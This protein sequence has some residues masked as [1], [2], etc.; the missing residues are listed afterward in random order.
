VAWGI[1][2][3]NKKDATFSIK[4]R[5]TISV[6]SLSSALILISLLFSFS[7]S[8]HEI[9]EVYDARLGQSA[10]MLLLSMPISEQSLHSDQT[11][12]LFDAWMQRIAA[13]SKRD[14]DPTPF[15]HPY[16]QNILVQFYFGENLIWGSIPGIGNI[17]HDPKYAGFGYMTLENESWRYFQLPL[18]SAPNHK[19]ESI[20]VAEK[21]S[22]R[23]EVI[24]E[25]ALSS[26]L[27]QLILIPCLALVMVLLID[28]HFEPLSELKL[29]IAQRSAN[30]LD[31]IYVPSATQE[32][33]P[34]VAALNDLLTELDQ[35]W[36]R[37]KRFTR[38]AAHELKTPLTILRLNAE[39]ALMSQNEQQLKSDLNNILQGIDRTDRLI[40]QLLTLAKVDSIHEMKFS[41]LN[42]SKLSKSV[43][44]ERVPLALTNKQDF[45][46]EGEDDVEIPGDEALLR[47]LLTNL[48]D[49]AIRYSG[50][51]S[52]I[53]V[54]V[55]KS[56]D[57][58]KVYVSDTGVDMSAETRQKLFDNFY[59]ANT[60]KGDGAGLG[61]SITRDIAKLH[62][63]SVELLP[64]ENDR[65]T[66][67][68][69]LPV[70]LLC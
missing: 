53:S 42:I 37:E 9:E 48:V 70:C 38:M 57:Q 19:P 68:V 13:Q 8:R 21:Q 67:L 33:S 15:G 24:H 56:P 4:K 17:E 62:K 6:I 63:G 59:R 14:G 31:S 11:R 34:L 29:A 26:A 69:T 60:E 28:K 1:S 3:K 58:V 25:L 7:S 39:N 64:R 61:M 32:L 47:M 18:P 51:G 10:K 30:K 55:E 23:D 35:A 50:E 2:L 27:P 16:E 49:N 44:A 40:H 46:F 43:I 22:I 5:L 41:S 36:Q 12:E 45:S 54:R 52:Q 65:N 66:F 20:I